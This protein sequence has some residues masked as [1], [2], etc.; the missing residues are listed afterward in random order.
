MAVSPLSRLSRVQALLATVELRAPSLA[1]WFETLFA[2]LQQTARVVFV[3][4]IHAEDDQA[5]LAGWLS[6]TCVAAVAGHTGSRL[7]PWAAAP[8]GT[9][10]SMGAVTTVALAW[11]CSNAVMDGL[12]NV[13]KKRRSLVAAE[14]DTMVFTVA[15]SK[16]AASGGAIALQVLL[17]RA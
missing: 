8:A 14:I 7:F 4:A 3:R 13:A 12:W 5:L 1:S 9:R 15:M 16:F 6:V 11:A 10:P 17:S 2:V